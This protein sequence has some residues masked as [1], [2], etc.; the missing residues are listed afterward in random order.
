[1]RPCNMIE[2]M[3]ATPSTAWANCSTMRIE[4]PSA[5]HG[6]DALVELLDD[7]RG[8][9]HRQLV[10]QEQRGVGGDRPG[11]GEH[12][13]LATRQRAGHLLAA[14][15]QPRE[16]GERLVLQLRE[17]GAGMGEHPEVLGDGEV[18]E[19]APALGHEAHP[20]PGQR[21][22][23]RPLHLA[24]ADQQLPAGRH[25]LPAADPE[26]RGLAGAVGAEQGVDLAGL[27]GEVHTVEHVD[28]A[29]PASDVVQLEDGGHAGTSAVV[30]AS[31][32]R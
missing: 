19:D 30:S 32:P 21:V 7:D 29:V 26:G 4:T 3:S 6:G 16:L 28:G 12:L 2:A 1:M 14:L 20:G 22:G 18:R 31:V 27:D 9:T 10:E 8:E 11:H 15:L 23:A 5:G 13:L 25:D 24:T 17:R